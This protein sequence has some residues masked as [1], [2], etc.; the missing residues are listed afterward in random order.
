MP[1]AQLG[2]S[3]H[4]LVSTLDLD[5]F[6]RSMGV[7]LSKGTGQSRKIPD[8]P[9]HTY[10]PKPDLNMQLVSYEHN[11]KPLYHSGRYDLYQPVSASLI[12]F[13]FCMLDL[14]LD[15]SICIIIYYS[16]VSNALRSPMSNMV[17]E[18]N[19]Q[20]SQH[21]MCYV[22]LYIHNYN[23]SALQYRLLQIYFKLKIILRVVIL[24]KYVHY[25][26]I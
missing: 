15:I 13:L 1:K 10:N 5:W 21:I 14:K 16:T 9:N 23:W 7:L 22:E 25:D 26:I 11:T 17:V 2:Q 8:K 12:I 3:P 4:F 20:L 24:E 19:F 6:P 18:T